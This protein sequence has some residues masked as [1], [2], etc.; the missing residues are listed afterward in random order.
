V[1]KPVILDDS[2]DVGIRLQAMLFLR[3]LGIDSETLIRHLQ[4]LLQSD[5]VED[6]DLVKVIA[7]LAT[8]GLTAKEFAED[9]VP[10][11]TTRLKAGKSASLNRYRFAELVSQFGTASVPALI[12]LIKK[13][14]HSAVLALRTIGPQAKEACPV[15][16]EYI[17]D[18]SVPAG[19]RFTAEKTL[20]E[21][22]K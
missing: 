21:I 18:Q 10:S 2:E 16:R 15:L 14:D 4:K 11:I 22:E 1:L 8:L 20:E 6:Q 3:Q 19:N 12:E 17:S 7:T 13:R 9:F 5:K